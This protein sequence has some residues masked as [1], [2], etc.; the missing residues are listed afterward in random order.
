[1]PTYKQRAVHLVEDGYRRFEIRFP[2][3]HG[4]DPIIRQAPGGHVV[5]GYLSDD[6]FADNPLADRD[7]AGHIHDRRPRH[8]AAESVAA[9]RA[10]MGLD[11]DGHPRPGKGPDPLAVLLDVYDHGGEAWSL[12]GGGVQNQWDT[13]RGAG[14]WVPDDCCREH[15]RYEAIRRQLPE[16]AS[17]SYVS[18]PRKTNVITWRLPD[19]RSRG[20]YRNF[21]TA[22]R[23]AARACGVAIDR[24][25]LAHDSRQVAVECAEQALEEYNA[26][27]AGACYGVSVEVFDGQGVR[28][29]EDD[30][31]GYIG[32]E[33]AQQT[34]D[35]QV[36]AML[37][38]DPG[39]VHPAAGSGAEGAEPQGLA[40]AVD[41]RAMAKALADRADVL[42]VNLYDAGDTE[43]AETGQERPD[44]AALQAAVDECRRAAGDTDDEGNAEETG[45]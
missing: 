43:E 25:Q 12:H 33:W 23:A 14:A 19:G 30:C 34:L 28:V 20:G 13:T 35:E 44:I 10:A 21:A 24:Q 29:K 15:I 41:W 37:V 39:Q 7:G 42:L 1:V 2:V 9:F 18:T 32:A 4:F 11:D 38:H 31:W 5:V 36:E 6:R 22:A 16:G 40:G 17:V 26:W 27:L 3:S 8:A 45:A